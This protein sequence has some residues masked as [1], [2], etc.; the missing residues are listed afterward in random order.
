[1]TDDDVGAVPVRC[2]IDAIAVWRSHGGTSGFGADDR[3]ATP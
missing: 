2:E 1:L 3:S